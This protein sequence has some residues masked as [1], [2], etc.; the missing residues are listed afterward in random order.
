MIKAVLFDADGVLIN[1]ERFSKQLARDYGIST[2]MTLP[3]FSSIFQ[4][5]L[6]GQADLKEKLPSYLKEWGWKGSVDAF[7]EY[8]F[9]SEHKIEKPVIEF[10]HELK[11]KGIR[12]SVATN[13]E[14]YRVEYMISQM[15][16][17]EIMEKVYSSA[18]LGFKKP[19]QEFFKAVVEDLKLEMD[20]ILFWDDDLENVEGAKL[21]GIH[22]ELYTSFEEFKSK[23]NRYL[24]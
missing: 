22:A 13:N 8:W 6:I 21:L 14:K 2:D 20:E 3:F 16:F 1:A 18:S 5:C 7:L 11:S 23:T 15:G 12:T 9:K 10:I 24:S 4:E 17:G 19:D